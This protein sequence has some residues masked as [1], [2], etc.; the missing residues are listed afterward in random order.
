MPGEVGFGDGD[1]KI[2]RRELLRLELSLQKGLS[3]M[4]SNPAF[5]DNVIIAALHYPPFNSRGEFSEFTGVMKKYGVQFC[6]YGHLHGDACKGAVEGMH[7]GVLFRL[8]PTIWA[9][10][11]KCCTVTPGVQ[12]PAKCGDRA[13][14]AG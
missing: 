13:T 9:L 7:D 12:K 4:S 11:P 14:A 8:Q 2:F 10:C 5:A 6:I 3:E 1:E